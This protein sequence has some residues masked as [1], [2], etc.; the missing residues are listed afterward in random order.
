MGLISR[1]EWQERAWGIW[2]YLKFSTVIMQ[3]MHGLTRGLQM[4]QYVPVIT[5][6]DYGTP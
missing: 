5:D 2:L 1:S 6:I 4:A 3:H